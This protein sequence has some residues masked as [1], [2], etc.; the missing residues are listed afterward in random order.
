MEVFTKSPST[1]LTAGLDPVIFIRSNWGMAS[2]FCYIM[3]NKPRGVLYVGVTKDLARRVYEHQTGAIEGFTNRYALKRLV[4]YEEYPMVM[5]AVQREK[6]IKHWSRQWKIE[7]IEK[8][9]PDW[10]DLFEQ[11]A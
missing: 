1:I 11:L 9:N 2:G 4:Y 7:L 5:D 3:T 6:N 10:K 8:S